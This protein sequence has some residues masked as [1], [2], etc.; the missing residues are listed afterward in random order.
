LSKGILVIPCPRC[1]APY[2]YGAERKAFT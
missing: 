2:D 1:A